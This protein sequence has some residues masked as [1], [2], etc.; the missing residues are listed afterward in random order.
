MT[1]KPFRNLLALAALLTLLPSATVH[2]DTTS[3]TSDQSSTNKD[4]R[5]HTGTITIVDAAERTVKVD[6][7]LLN[8]TF[9]L[10]ADCSFAVGLDKPAT[11]DQLK[12]SMEV[13]VRYEESD[14]VFIATRISQRWY[15][16]VGYVKTATPANHEIVLDRV[17]TARKFK[18]N[19]STRLTIHNDKARLS[20]YKTGQ[21][22]TIT[23]TK[24]DDLWLAHKVEDTSERFVG[25]VEAI[26]AEANTMKV[27]NLL[28]TKKFNLGDGCKIVFNNDTSGKLRN[29][30][31]G[32]KVT[33]NYEDMKGVLVAGR[34]ELATDRAPATDNTG[35]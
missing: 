32:E 11:L 26:D 13:V 27:K 6:K 34:I 12:P 20:D 21:K 8:K 15:T 5:E 19:D 10:A 9:N 7:F 18:V 30:R 25:T 16:Q 17:G 35:P 3:P 2:A 14:G 33:V 4:A 29:V 28:T 23:Y 31:L 1:T 24:Q 22:V